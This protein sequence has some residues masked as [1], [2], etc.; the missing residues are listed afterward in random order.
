[1]KNRKD[2]PDP[3][4]PSHHI[5]KLK[6]VLNTNKDSEKAKE[7]K[8][9][10]KVFTQVC[11]RNASKKRIDER[12]K[13]HSKE[14]VAES[15]PE[16]EVKPS[17]EEKFKG[18]PIERKS[19]PFI[20]PEQAKSPLIT[21]KPKQFA[22][23]PV[24][25]S[26]DTFNPNQRFFPGQRMPQYYCQ[27]QN[28]SQSY[29]SMPMGPPHYPYYGHYGPPDNAMMPGQNFEKPHPHYPTPNNFI[30]NQHRQHPTSSP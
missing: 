23:N 6:S 13:A 19:R 15:K 10:L 11:N 25:Q 3:K 30:Q 21:K 2:R 22:N 7:E 26:F 20:P 24:S 16:P 18:L 27:D 28:L 8:K 14:K 29:N 4:F 5:E 9:R 12:T 1:M 17:E